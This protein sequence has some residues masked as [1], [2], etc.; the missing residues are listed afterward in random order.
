V[1]DH[2]AIPGA[3]VMDGATLRDEILGALREAITG[4]GSPA[5]CL[6][7]IVVGDDP[8]GR[9]NVAAK[10]RAAE[11]AGM[12]WR[13]A[14]LASTA[15]Q[16]DVEEA[17]AALVAD[18]A[19]HGVFVQLPLPP[20]LSEEPVLDRVSADKD[21]DGLSRVN[22]GRLVRGEPGHVPCTPA[23]ALRLLARHNVATK[24]R[25]A[26]VVGRSRFVA[27]PAALL[28]QRAGCA[29]VT[30]A[31]PD[32]PDLA[33]LCCD[34]D[35]VVA[36]ADR[37]RLI[38]AAH[39]RP[40]AAVIDAGVTRTT[41]GVVGDVDTVTVGAVA[42]AIAPMPGGVGPV[43]IACL[44]SHTLAAARVQGVRGDWG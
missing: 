37:P 42:G 24:G 6:G 15:T 36:A 41:E 16:A 30:V 4:I 14:Q 2:G 5:V 28:L 33:G 39:I 1:D 35:I 21:V 32:A 11:A 13:H 40:G 10:H 20:G 25:R 23:A 26:V 8:A 12:H 9:A 34:A 19:V 18:P 38:G 27:L 7:T 44:L 17:V 43:T 22:L 31:D 3:V 29:S